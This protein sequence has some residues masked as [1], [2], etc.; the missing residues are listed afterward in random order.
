MSKNKYINN[1]EFITKVKRGIDI[2]HEA[3]TST[4]GGSGRNIMY[5]DYTQNPVV[6]NDGY[7]IA[8]SI[9]LEDEAEAMGADFLKQASRRQNFEAGDG[10]TTVIALAHAMIE[11]GLEK[12]KEGANPM[13]LK[14][15]M[16][17]SV[18][19][20]IDKL[21]KKAEKIKTDK[22]LFDVANI[23]MENPD[24]AQL[25]V[26]SIGKM[27]ENG[28]IVV[29]ESIGV[30]TKTEEVKGIE[31]PSGYMSPYMIN[32]ASNLTAYMEDVHVLIADKQF[33]LLKDLFP[34][35]EGLKN[36]GH[37]NLLI[38][39]REVLGEAMGNLI[40]NIQK[41]AFFTVAVQAPGDRN[42]L[43]DI[44]ILTGSTI[45]NEVNCPGELTSLHLNCLGKAKRVIV[46]RERSIID[47]DNGSKKDI[48]ARIQAI[49]TEIKDTDIEAFKSIL[50]DRL[51]RLSGKVIYIKVGSPTQQ[52]MKYLKL[53]IDDAV[54]SAIA[55]KRSGIVVGGG[56][57]L[58]DMGQD[59]Y[60]SDGDEV[61][62]TACME[63]M[64]KIIENAKKDPKDIIP[65][66]SKGQAWNSLT[67][68]PV[69]DYVKEG[70]VDPVDIEIWALRNAVSTAGMFL[71]TAGALIP[72]PKKNF[73]T[74]YP[75]RQM[76]RIIVK[77]ILKLKEKYK[78][79]ALYFPDNDIYSVRFR[80][81]AV[82]N[83]NSMQFYQI[84][85]RHRF[86]QI[87]QILRLGL[88]HNRGERSMM[89]QIYM[90]RSIGKKI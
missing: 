46:S 59:K 14:R 78:V 9:E 26:D 32:N 49:K 40:A 12:V 33:N 56:R 31:L 75:Y 86:N 50:R 48:E 34:I 42:V 51:A 30:T 73:S 37:S 36:K 35:L 55:A 44:A 27:G 82:Q 88:N 10:T 53:K 11:K 38:I 60:A 81:Q 70:L 45:I 79:E 7:T 28:R 1:E 72:V 58:Y 57:A 83:F 54:A 19:K 65:K 87:G 69:I 20:I 85:Q 15:E 39:C 63:P 2:V 67:E 6:T 8:E 18:I 22:E 52:E 80:G 13:K 43:E 84:P 29:E 61:V 24:M 3:V 16:N 76:N 21:K 77:F 68:K 41:G 62:K 23:S 66:L 25:V 74:G 64:T 4:L 47:S 17:E 90:N 89:N 5:R 71:T